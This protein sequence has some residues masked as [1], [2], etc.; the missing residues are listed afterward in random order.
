M[1]SRA[2]QK[3]GDRTDVGGSRGLR[4]EGRRW[5]DKK[6]GVGG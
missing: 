3:R 6:E 1:T 2:G 4:R 5:E